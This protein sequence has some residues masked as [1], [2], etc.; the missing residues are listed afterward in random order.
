MLRNVVNESLLSIAAESSRII[1]K[2]REG[3]L[4]GAEMQG[5]VFTITN[6]GSFGIDTFTPVINLPETAIL[7]LGAIRKL[8]VVASD[9]RIEV[10][11]MMTLSLTFD[12]R[13]IDGRTS[14]KISP[15]PCGCHRKSSRTPAHE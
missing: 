11:P 9:D 10:R 12:H 14:G 7:G 1:R 2:S 15:I 13:A 5:A 8:A 6:L 3:R 4:S